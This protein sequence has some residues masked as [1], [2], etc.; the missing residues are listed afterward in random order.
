MLF[1][2]PEGGHLAVQDLDRPPLGHNRDR[3]SALANA[4]PAWPAAAALLPGVARRAVQ[5]MSY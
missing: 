2:P 4:T 5:L 1:L 3:T